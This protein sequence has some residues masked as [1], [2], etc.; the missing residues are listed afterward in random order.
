[1]YLILT[2]QPYH[3]HGDRIYLTSDRARQLRLLRNSL[4]GKFGQLSVLAP[5][6]AV[7]SETA[8]HADCEAGRLQTFDTAREEIRVEP[9]L[10]SGWGNHTSDSRNIA[11]RPGTWKK[12]LQSFTQS[13]CVL[14]P[15]ILSP[16]DAVIA[17]GIFQSTS[18]SHPIVLVHS[19]ASNDDDSYGSRTLSMRDRLSNRRCRRR[20]E[21]LAK[22]SELSLFSS[23]TSMRQYSRYARNSQL[24][25]EPPISNEDVI[26]EADLLRRL[27][28]DVSLQP[29]R[30]VSYAPLENKYG[31]NLSIAV[32][33]YAIQFGANVVLDIYGQGFQR[34]EL[35]YQIAKLGLSREVSFRQIAPSVSESLHQ[36]RQYDA[37]LLTPAIDCGMHRF[38]SCYSSGLPMLGF[39]HPGFIKQIASDKAGM[40]LP[41]NDLEKAGQ[42][43]AELELH[44][45]QLYEMSLN[46]R[47]AACRHSRES[48]YAKRAEWTVN[49]I[50]RFALPSRSS[51][52]PTTSTTTPA[53][54]NPALS[55]Q[56]T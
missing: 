16:T 11:N 17:D 41:K 52:P 8:L 43:I 44:R 37:M 36:Q 12:I 28:G 21:R 51:T 40:L 25:C 50:P 27:R 53:K 38:L 46:A 55:G 45:G 14:Q 6:V 5:A 10:Q 18:I 34:S 30:L 48:W 7:D 20:C 33:R 3:L 56:P 4:D 35:Q 49:A 31:V 1:M 47:Q 24:F 32:V 9:V 54:N 2:C 19:D 39:D 22:R 29:L 15:E 13:A 23:E 26:S 42:R